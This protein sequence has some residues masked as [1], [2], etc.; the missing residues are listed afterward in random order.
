[1]L[2]AKAAR[3]NPRALAQALVAA[4]PAS[5][6]RREGRDRR[7]GLHQLPPGAGCLRARSRAR[8]SRSGVGYGRNASGAGHTVGVEYVSANPT[9][10]LHVGHGRAAAIGDCIARV[11]DANGW[12]VM[13]EF[14]YNDAGAQI[15]NLAMSVQARAQGKT[16][17]RCRLAGRRLPRRLHP[18]R[19]QRLPARR[20]GRVR[21]P[22]RAPARR[23]PTTSTRSAASPSPTCAANRTRD[24]A[25]YGVSFDVYFLESLAVH[26]TARSRKPCAS[27]SPT[28]TP[29][30]KAARCGCARPTSATTRTA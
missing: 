1:M 26:A 16:P 17:G 27:W 2:L 19:R 10:P 12:N 20:H 21:R 11:L 9:G 6:R 22:H 24:L 3:T 30:R 18:R 14:Y 15:D 8:S 25:A 29:T 4:L 28:A 7:P 23:I 13:R 5:R